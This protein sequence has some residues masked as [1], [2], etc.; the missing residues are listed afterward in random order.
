MAKT[1][2]KLTA[3]KVK[4]IFREDIVYKTKEYHRFKTLT[5]NRPK[6]L[7][8]V[9]RLRISIEENGM[10][11]N[12]VMVNEKFEIIDG[13]HRFDGA[14][15]TN[16]FI[17]VQFVFG[18]DIDKVHAL[19]QNQSNWNSKDYMN[20]YAEMGLKDYID[21]RNFYEKHEVFNITDCITMCSNVTSIAQY[22][23]SEKIRKDRPTSSPT[24]TFNEGTWKVKDLEKANYYAEQLKR[25]GEFFDGY[26]K[27]SFVGTM[28]GLMNR[29]DF[30]ME[31]FVRKLSMRPHI[32]S[33]SASRDQYRALIEDVYNHRRR[34]KVNLRF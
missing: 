23:I 13:Q 19:N 15:K 22:Q 10:L 6:N 28:I 21:L 18:Y 7:Q 5:G 20:G 14:V 9:E 12:P 24:M 4:K 17:Y 8:H 34:E 26:N 16:E 11:I 32:L 31:E 33:A 27:T 3:S 2:K 1:S 25:V 30:D 29:D